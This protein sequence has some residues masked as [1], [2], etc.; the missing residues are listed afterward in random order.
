MAKEKRP[1]L[2]EPALRAAAVPMI[3]E[4]IRLFWQKNALSVCP[5]IIS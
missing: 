4:N 5:Q 3:F 2:G 1:I